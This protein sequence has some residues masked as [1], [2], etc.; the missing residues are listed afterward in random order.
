MKKSSDSLNNSEKILLPVEGFVRLP[1]ILQLFPIGRSTWWQGVK[2]GKYPQP[3]KLAER[4]TV[5]KAK[6]IREMLD[7]YDDQ[8]NEEAQ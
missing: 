6:D 8:T 7:S 3:V 4:T 1:K 2:T 5:W